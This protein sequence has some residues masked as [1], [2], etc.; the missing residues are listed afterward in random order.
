MAHPQKFREHFPDPFFELLAEGD[1]GNQVEHVLSAHEDFPGQFHVDFG[2]AGTGHP[3]EECRLPGA[4]AFLHLVERR[5]LRRCQDDGA[6]PGR[7][8]GNIQGTL[9]KPGLQG[10][11]FRFVPCPGVIPSGRGYLL[12]LPLQPFL[13]PGCDPCFRL[14]LRD[15][16]SRV[17]CLIDLS[18]RTE[19]VSGHLPPQSCLLFRDP[20]KRVLDGQCRP[21]PGKTD[22]G[23]LFPCVRI[24]DHSDIF[25]PRECNPDPVSRHSRNGTVPTVQR[26]PLQAERDEDFYVL[27]CIHWRCCHFFLYLRI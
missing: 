26:L 5:L 21:Y 18:Y 22:G 11:P 2:L 14:F 12:L 24:G 15:L 10:I 20:G 16:P 27:P 23:C 13:Q 17:G 7:K 8:G 25:L 1:L 4:D 19:V 9:R 6:G 3:V